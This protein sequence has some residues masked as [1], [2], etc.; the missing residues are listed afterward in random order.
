MGLKDKIGGYF[1]RR[2]LY[3]PVQ[4]VVFFTSKNTLP[5]MKITYIFCHRKLALSNGVIVIAV[6]V[7]VCAEIKW[8]FYF[9]RV[10]RNWLKANSRQSN[11]VT[12]LFSSQQKYPQAN[13]IH[14]V[15]SRTLYFE[16]LSSL[17]FW[18][19]CFAYY[20][21]KYPSGTDWQV[22]ANTSQSI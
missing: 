8:K 19:M 9:R 13:V 14:N 11:Y 21:E 22:S 10:H 17:F 12:I 7:V 2:S 15:S 5:I 6:S 18:I 4:R 16:L 20:N 3:E 1:S